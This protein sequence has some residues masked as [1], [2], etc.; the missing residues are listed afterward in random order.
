MKFYQ[1]TESIVIRAK[2]E[3]VY[4]ALTN[5]KERMAW[6]RGLMME[7]DGPDQAEVGQKITAGLNKFPSTP[8][9]FQITQL[10]WPYRI[11]IEYI[12]TP[13][14]GRAAF[15]II[16]EGANCYVSFYWMKVEVVG[17]WNRLYFR[18]GFGLK[19]H[20][21]RSQK[22]LQLLKEHLEKP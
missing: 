10:E 11:F 2:P 13:F 4:E 20:K 12:G 19:T 22:T 1:S 18:L 16:P 9:Q 8:F 17:F 14:Q 5:W 21:L 7:W 15:E 6:R 3:R